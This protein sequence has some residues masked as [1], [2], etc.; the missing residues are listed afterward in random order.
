VTRAYDEAYLGKARTVL[1]RTLDFLVFD[2][3]N[4]I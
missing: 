4:Y 1:A 3:K 2:F